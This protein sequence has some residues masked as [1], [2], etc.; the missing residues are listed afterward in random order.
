MKWFVNLKI[1]AKLI[2][3]FL[4]VA[5]IAAIVGVVGVISITNISKS[6]TELYEHDTLS[7]QYSGDAAV[8]MQQLRY[9]LVKISYIDTA[10][11]ASINELLEDIPVQVKNVSEAMEECAGSISEELSSHFNIIQT[12]WNTYKDGADDFINYYESGNLEAA[13]AMIPELAALGT[14]IRDNFIELF[15]HI[16]ES[17]AEGA[18]GNASQAAQSTILMIVVIIVGIMIAVVLGIYIS[19]IIGTPVKKMAAVGNLLAA[20]DLD[21]DSVLTQKDYEL[22]LRRD[23]VGM[24]SSAFHDLITST[25]RQ[26]Q[27]AQKVAQADLTVDVDV[28]SDRDLLNAELA[29]LTDSLNKMVH[30]ISTASEQVAAGA[31]QV[32]DSSMALSQGATEQASSIEELTASLEEI[33]S[34]TK[35]NAENAGKANELSSNAKGDAAQGNTQ[36]QEMLKAMDEINVSSSNIYKIIKVID[37]IAFQTNILALNAAVEAARAGSAGKGFAVVA[38]EVKNLAQKSS[39][40]ASETT[41]MIE[42]SIQKVEGGTKIAKDTAEALGKIV[43]EVEKVATLVNDISVASNEQAMGIEQI[44]QGIMQV[45]QVV[46]SNSATSEESAAASEELSSQAALLSQLVGQFKLKNSGDTNT[47]SADM[48][49]KDHQGNKSA[50]QAAIAPAKDKKK[51]LLSDSE[52]GKY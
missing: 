39:E 31:K 19:R 7:L 44:N 17:A 41:A 47:V 1:S 3:G 16:S 21:M 33:S 24:L 14:T 6:D 45:S 12:D 11:T 29:V 49:K 38:E 46:Q 9:D 32:S 18:A 5:A 20:G 36:M 42:S 13:N 35:L 34:Q 27:V 50:Q 15:N 48:E 8:S 23:E 22:K 40:A 51:I 52:F 4:V 26:V 30:E 37:D 25:T 28:R 2:A 43:D 10:D